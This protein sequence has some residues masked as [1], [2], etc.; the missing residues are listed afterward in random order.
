MRGRN[1]LLTLIAIVAVVAQVEAQRAQPPRGRRPPSE[2][3][4]FVGAAVG[5]QAT[6]SDFDARTNFPLYGETPHFDTSYDLP[7]A[8]SF[9]VAGGVR[10]WR[11]LGVA[12]AV[13]RHERSGDAAISASVP[14]PFFFNRPR[15]LDATHPDLSRSETAIHVGA[16]WF[17]PLTRRLLL[18]LS[19]GPSFISYT[20]DIVTSLALLEAYPY[21]SVELLRGVTA[22]RDG[23]AIGA[24]AS[25][26]VYYRLTRR[27]S[28]CRS[29]LAVCRWAA[30]SG[31]CSE[32]AHGDGV[33]AACAGGRP[34]HPAGPRRNIW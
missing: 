9:D 3:R 1:L 20:Q 33:R 14:H 22:R 21:D 27:P 17:K 10:V 18:T 6:G 32:G 7:P 12:V 16:L 26:D 4:G 29:R 34:E 11:D 24:Y 5:A 8:F 28:R 15:A 30:A 31:G 25:G 2:P 19:G 23:V 13:S